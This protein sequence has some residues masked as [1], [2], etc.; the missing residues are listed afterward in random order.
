MFGTVSLIHAFDNETTIEL[1]GVP[2]TTKLNDQR[3]EISVGGEWKID[4]SSVFFGGL[5]ASGGLGSKG[6]DY[7][8]GAA[9]GLQVN[10]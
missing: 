5:T 3:I 9:I 8:Y 4:D 2:F 7:S 6:E 10:F 1:E